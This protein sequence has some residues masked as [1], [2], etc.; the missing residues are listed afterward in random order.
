MENNLNMPKKGKYDIGQIVVSC[1]II[2]GF[3]IFMAV[4]PDATLAAVNGLFDVL[5]KYLGGVLETFTFAAVVVS[6]L[7]YRRQ[8]R[9]CE[10]GR[11]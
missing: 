4:K 7:L 3:V 9:Q 6:V 1:A 8:V 11:G 2:F 10:T 5:I